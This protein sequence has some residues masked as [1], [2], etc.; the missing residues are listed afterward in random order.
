MNDLMILMSITLATY[1]GSVA[2]T[3]L[4]LRLFFP[5]KTKEE[6]EKDRNI[7]SFAKM[8]IVHGRSSISLVNLKKSRL[9][10]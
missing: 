7:E 6:M 5:F 3:I 10:A 4:L 8:Q 9:L 1:L 2:F